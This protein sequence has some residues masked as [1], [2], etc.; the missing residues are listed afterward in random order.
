M[1][2]RVADV[3]DGLSNTMILGE[4]AGR[5]THW[6]STGKRSLPLTA[7]M[8]ADDDS[9]SMSLRGSIWPPA[10]PD[11]WVDVGFGPC[12]MNC[13]NK[14]ELFSFHQGGVNVVHGDGSARFINNNIEIALLGHLFTRSGGEPSNY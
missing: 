8:W 13:S 9:M 10:N 2:C 7:G 4:V 3:T 1:P 12:P 5:P 14:S 6:L 11:D